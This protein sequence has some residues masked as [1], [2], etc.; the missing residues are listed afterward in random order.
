MLFVNVLS[1]Q[2]SVNYYV[3][4]ERGL[5]TAYHKLQCCYMNVTVFYL[6]QREQRPHWGCD[7]C[8]YALHQYMREC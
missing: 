6:F 3:V 1:T 7:S 2:R 5:Y 8:L 4:H